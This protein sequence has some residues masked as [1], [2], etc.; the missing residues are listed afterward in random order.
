MKPDE[1][2]SRTCD[3]E[4]CIVCAEWR[5]EQRQKAM[6]FRIARARRSVGDQATPEEYE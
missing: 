1:A 3:R 4:T 5:R 2:H 6:P